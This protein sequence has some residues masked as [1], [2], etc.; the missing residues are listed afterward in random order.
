MK[1]KRI[2]LT[3]DD[4][5]SSHLSKK[6]D[7]LIEKKIPAIFYC[8]GEFMKEN[9]RHVSYAI[10]KGYWIGNHSYSHPYFSTISLD[11]AKEEIEKTDAFIEKA[12]EDAGLKRP[13]KLFRFPFL[14]RG[15]KKGKEHFQGL[16]ELLKDLGYNKPHF[17]GLTYPFC[18]GYLGGFDAP[19]T[20][21]AKEYALFSKEYMKKHA[22]YHPQDFQKLLEKV[23]PVKGYSLQNP[24]SADVLLLHDFET[25]HHVFEP[26]MDRLIEW[27]VEFWMPKIS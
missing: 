4:A 1:K 10:E 12:Y 6:V 15:E 20:V 26:I 3:I 13:F 14:D 25:T 23:D 7:Y 2:F 17:E 5:P 18:E 9:L 16:Q 24:A 22:L 19:F 27:D 11:L 8:R 21:D